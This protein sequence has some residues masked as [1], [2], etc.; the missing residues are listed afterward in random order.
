HVF[1]SLIMS[2]SICALFGITLTFASVSWKLLPFILILVGVENTFILTNA[3]TSIPTQLNVKERI[4]KGLEK[5]GYTNTKMLICWLLVLLL[6]SMISIDIQEFCIFTS[7]AMII[8]YVLQ[9]TFFV[10]VLSIDLEWFEL[11]KICTYYADNDNTDR[12][13]IL[14]S[15]T[16]NYGRRIGCSLVVLIFLVWVTN[17]YHTNIEFTNIEVPSALSSLI[18]NSTAPPAIHTNIT[19]WE[20][21]MDKTA[22]EFWSIVNP[23][24][25][26]QIV[27]ILPTRH[28]TLS[29]D[30]EQDDISYP[31]N[32]D[33]NW[34]LI[35]K[36]FVWFLKYIILPI[37]GIV[38]TTPIMM[39]FTSP[40]KLVIR[41]LEKT[42]SNECKN[43]LASPPSGSS[44][45]YATIPQ[46]IT[47]RG[48]HLADI[49]LLCANL[50]G[51]II[52]C[53]TDKHITSWN[54]MQGTPL[55]KLER[56]MRRCATCKCDSTGGMKS[57]ISWPVRAM[58][59][60]EKTAAAG[61][62]DG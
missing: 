7:I 25:K 56:Y 14:P 51:V 4:A 10:A 11:E 61:F 60:S 13:I 57:C 18:G 32:G 58:C 5:V 50:N 39:G 52:T 23:D 15:K 22:N 54:G 26:D 16:A 43:I 17:I 47:L 28:L 45:L 27:E 24:K 31:F 53:A 48:R 33:I 30:I 36:T 6:F 9:I 59:M 40:E 12:N 44:S 1:A 8:D 46:I 3:V 42:S 49:D 19:F 62:E 55:R 2:L 21:S 35:I 34:R 20:T 38:F 29:Y 41:I 37:I